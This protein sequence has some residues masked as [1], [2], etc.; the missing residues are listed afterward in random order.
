MKMNT[1]KRAY[2]VGVGREELIITG[3]HIIEMVF[4]VLN[5]DRAIVIDDGLREGV[6]LN[7]YSKE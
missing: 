7:Y 6:A 5:Y 2:Y 3:I 1:A 4:N